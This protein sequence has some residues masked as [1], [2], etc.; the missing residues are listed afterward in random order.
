M[1]WKI[2]FHRSLSSK[3]LCSEY[4]NLP[5]K[6]YKTLDLKIIE[7]YTIYDN[8]YIMVGCGESFWSHA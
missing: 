8:T 5:L 1:I 2:I 3:S 4:I 7:I 6:H